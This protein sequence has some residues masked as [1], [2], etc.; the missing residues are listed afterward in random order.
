MRGSSPK[1]FVQRAVLYVVFKSGL[2]DKREFEQMIAKTP[3][4]LWG[5]LA[6][7][8][9]R[10]SGGK[11]ETQNMGVILD[12]REKQSFLP[13]FVEKRIRQM[14]HHDPPLQPFEVTIMLPDDHASRY[15]VD[16]LEL[17][18]VD[19]VCSPMSFPSSP[20]A[21]DELIAN[22][23]RFTDDV[24]YRARDELRCSAGTFYESPA[25]SRGSSALS[26][27]GDLTDDTDAG[28]SVHPIA[29]FGPEPYKC[30]R[31]VQLS[32]AGHL[33]TKLGGG[34]FC[35]VRANL[36]LKERRWTYFEMH[37]SEQSKRRH[38]ART[39]PGRRGRHQITG[40]A[41]AGASG[42]GGGGG[43]GGG[44]VCGK[45]KGGNGEMSSLSVGLSTDHFPLNM[46][47]G[48]TCDSV[49]LT[50]SGHVVA[51]SKWIET[52]DWAS[53][54]GASGASGGGGSGCAETPN[55]SCF[56]AGDT[57]GVLV[58]RFVGWVGTWHE[59]AGRERCEW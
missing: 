6:E 49:G 22:F 26:D 55:L 15:P 48:S 37:V 52:A 36:P 31:D 23:S 18:E 27:D 41:A 8:C 53:R 40:G 1:E 47:V 50:S 3:D 34:L 51:D 30:H 7:H 16:A 12:Y 54:D 20:M 45:P 2:T 59:E 29:H 4:Q 44:G 42:S 33:A 19:S 17:R 14:M 58:S 11:E 13:S 35:S 56:S 28:L 43:G 39:T 9:R 46:L 25:T 24:V 38:G 5:D 21:R 32:C 10:F 57:V